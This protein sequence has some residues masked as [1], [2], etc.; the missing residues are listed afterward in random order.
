MSRSLRI[1]VADD[2]PRMCAYFKK[3][4]PRLGH[5][6]VSTASTGRELVEQCRALKPDLI[7]TDINMPDLDEHDAFRRLQ[8]LA[9]ERNQKLIE[10]AHI[11]VTAETALNL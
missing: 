1:A 9:S 8:K 11:I 3:M 5:E 6:V 7:I 4:L 10:I 2:E